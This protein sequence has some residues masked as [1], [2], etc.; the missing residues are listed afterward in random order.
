MMA[1]T[2]NAVA[3]HQSH[4]RLSLLAKTGCA[5]VVLAVLSGCAT[6][7]TST[8]EKAVEARANARWASWVKR[9]YAEAYKY[10][11]PGYR[12]TVPVDKFV[13]LR[14]K[15][16]RIL[17]GEVNKV[18]CDKPDHC[19]ARVELTAASALMTR[20]NFPKQI[21]TYVDEIWLLEDGQWW[22]FEP[23]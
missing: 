15:D 7:G 12:A 18:T 10:N 19:V 21:V 5:A 17:K 16:V 3:S 20:Y 2:M 6:F 23:L 22:I 11:T 8:P 13:S 4:L 1:A 14:G 9:D